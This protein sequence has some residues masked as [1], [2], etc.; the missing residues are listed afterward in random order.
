MSDAAIAALLRRWQALDVRD[1]H[2]RTEV[3]KLDLQCELACRLGR[4]IIQEQ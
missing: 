2:V 3:T 1:Y 4:W